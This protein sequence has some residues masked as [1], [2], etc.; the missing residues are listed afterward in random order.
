MEFLFT[1]KERLI[2]SVLADTMLPMGG[3]IPYGADELGVSR[4]VETFCRNLPPE[5]QK[6]IRILLRILNYA[7]IFSH[8]KTFIKLDEQKRK[9]FL[10]K[11]ENSKLMAK[12]NILTAV[13]SLIV[14]IYFNNP[15]VAKIIGYS[16]RCLKE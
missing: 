8:F 1:P 9:R 7:P 2:L 10:E 5:A 11:W 4:N 14:L 3:R 13:K 15:D 16:P 12:R 6:G